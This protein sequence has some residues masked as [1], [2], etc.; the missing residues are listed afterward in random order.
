MTSATISLNGLHVSFVGKLGGVNRREAAQLVRKHG[1]TPVDHRETTAD[2]VVI[3]ADELPL[4]DDEG[5]L[6]EATRQAAAE[7]KLEIIS[8]TQFWQCIGLVEGEQ[9][10]RRLYTPAMLA[11]LLDVS[12]ATVRRWHRRKLIV[13]VRE[14]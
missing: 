13:P 1:G 10:I 2:L 12:V 14:V 4:G 6:D 3:G 7:G 8:E 5:L 9:N 11:K